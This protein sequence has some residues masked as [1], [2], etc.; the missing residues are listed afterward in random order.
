M[1]LFTVQV[2]KYNQLYLCGS[3]VPSGFKLTSKGKSFIFKFKS[4]KKIAKTGFSAKVTG[5]KFL[6]KKT[7]ILFV[8]ATG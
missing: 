8:S 2:A 5:N 1:G 3:G 6:R 4:N 7:H